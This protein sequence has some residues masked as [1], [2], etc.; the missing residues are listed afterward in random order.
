LIFA[1][2]TPFVNPLRRFISGPQPPQRP[3]AGTDPPRMCH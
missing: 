2:V 1:M 3:L